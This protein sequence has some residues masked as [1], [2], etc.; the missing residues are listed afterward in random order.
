MCVVRM[1]MGYH[2]GFGIDFVTSNYG[3]DIL[4][5]VGCIVT[6]NAIP[7]SENETR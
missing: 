7:D 3:N 1:A 5:V 2:V 4:S 6:A